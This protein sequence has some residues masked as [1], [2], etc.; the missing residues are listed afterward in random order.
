MKIDIM[1]MRRKYLHALGLS[2][3]LCVSAAWQPNLSAA[4]PASV[5]AAPGGFKYFVG[6]SGNPSVPDIRWS[7]EQLE[8]IKALGLNMVQLSIAN[9]GRWT[10]R[11]WPAKPDGCWN[12]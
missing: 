1:K 12:V 6:I 10:R 9:A 5:N 11:N 7:D 2:A 8:Q 3:A 4:E